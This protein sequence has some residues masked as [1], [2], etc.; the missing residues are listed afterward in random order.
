MNAQLKTIGA[1]GQISFGKQ[2]AGRQVLVEEQGDGVWLVRTAQ[3]IPDNERWLHTP[4]TKAALK[5]ALDWAAT[6]EPTGTDLDAFFASIEKEVAD[7]QQQ[8]SKKSA[9]TGKSVSDRRFERP[10]AQAKLPRARK[11]RSTKV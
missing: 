1:S 7:D 4:E 2:H 5:I 10:H 8:K 11:S 3:V 6:H 9:A